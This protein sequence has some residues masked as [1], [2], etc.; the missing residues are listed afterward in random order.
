MT[1]RDFTGASAWGDLDVVR[2][3]GC[4]QVYLGA[5]AGAGKTC[6]MLD[7][8]Q[9]RRRAGTNV[10]AG[11]VDCHG[12][13][14]TQER[15]AGLEIIPRKVVEY[16]GARF[17]EMDLDA[18]LSRRPAV[19]LIDELAHG[20]VPGSGRHAKRWQDV[21]ALLT[22][23]IDVIT[24]VNVQQLDS[25]AGAI[26]RLSGRC[27]RERVPD[28]VVRRA[29]RIEFVDCSPEQL[30]YRILRG[31]I[32]P[33]LDIPRALVNFFMP[34]NLAAM[35]QLG[36]RFIAG[37]TEQELLEMLRQH[38]T[39][40]SGESAER[41]MVAVTPQPGMDAVVRRIWRITA[42]IG[43]D[44][45]VVHICNGDTV[46]LPGHDDLAAL[47]CL[48][49]DLGA[50]WNELEDYDT[51]GALIRFAIH[52]RITHI[53]LGPGRRGRWHGTSGSVVRRVLRLATPAGIDVHIMAMAGGPWGNQ[54][55][56]ESA[57]R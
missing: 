17:E 44:L 52:R 31:D 32:C 39:G 22:A 42:R 41:F 28:W 1:V 34:G 18:V 29:G 4:L 40:S 12:R 24:T 21:L 30:R 33:G 16:R 11:F 10:V 8:G 49:V 37:D 2:T 38:E 48:A 5:A 3:V 19:V 36:R 23:G 50:T 51:A 13:P 7:E 6:A 53:V 9:R 45:H 43:A 46:P 57:V 47:R 35:R 20:N 27:V 26:E 25:A 15:A 55:E 14:R 54:P 56:D